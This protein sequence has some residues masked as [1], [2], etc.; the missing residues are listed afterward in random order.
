MPIAIAP[1]SGRLRS[2][3]RMAILNPSPSAPSRALF[4]MRTSSKTTSPVS[5]ARWP[6]LF[7]MRCFLMP[8][9]SAGKTKAVMP[10]WRSLR[11]RVAK[12]TYQ[13]ATV[14]FEMKCLVPFSTYS[15]PSAVGRRHA[16]HVGAGA[17]LGDAKR[18][19]GEL[20]R[21]LAQIAALLLLGAGE[22]ERGGREAVGGDGVGDPRA[23][24]VELLE[25]E[26]AVEDAQVGPPEGGRHLEVHEP[27]LPRLAR[28]VGGER[29]LLV[30]ARRHREDLLAGKPARGLL[31][32]LLLGGEIEAQ[33]G[34]VVRATAARVNRRRARPRRPL[35][36]PRAWRPPAP[37][38]RAGPAYRPPSARSPEPSPC[39]LAAGCGRGARSRARRACSPRA[40]RRARRQA[41]RPRRR[42]G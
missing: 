4:G 34:D 42:W 23:G 38:S 12:A 1:I 15:S 30:V 40:P 17:R 5:A 14:P 31:E 3:V 13:L 19:E 35:P 25:H 18:S 10:A 28:D 39:P 32:L 22:A 29:L 2:N 41:A 26:T 16:R 8:G 11:S 20:G 36:P 7:F 33:H 27:E 6:S 24:V 37:W 21:E 9:R